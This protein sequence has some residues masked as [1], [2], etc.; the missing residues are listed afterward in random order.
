M[1]RPL[2]KDLRE[3][4]VGC[5]RRGNAGRSRLGVALFCIDPLG[6][7]IEF[8]DRKDLVIVPPDIDECVAKLLWYRL[9]PPS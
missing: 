6:V 7:N 5:S 8:E 2:S 3:R 4:V 1:T 9:L